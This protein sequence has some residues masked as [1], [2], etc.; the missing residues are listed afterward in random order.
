MWVILKISHEEV[1]AKRREHGARRGGE[2]LNAFGGGAPHGNKRRLAYLIKAE[3]VELE[4]S[5]LL[6]CQS[7]VGSW[8]R[9]F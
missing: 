7:L 5:L 8:A 3:D 6:L 9:T 2:N 4:S 1:T